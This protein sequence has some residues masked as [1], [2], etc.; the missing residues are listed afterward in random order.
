MH[1]KICTNLQLCRLLQQL[2]RPPAS[3][4][5]S[6]TRTGKPQ[7]PREPRE[8]K[9]AAVNAV[10]RAEYERQLSEYEARMLDHHAAVSTGRAASVSEGESS[11]RHPAWAAWAADIERVAAR[12]GANEAQLLYDEGLWYEPLD[13]EDVP[14]AYEP[15][16][17]A[18]AHRT[19]QFQRLEGLGMPP[20]TEEKAKLPWPHREWWEDR[21]RIVLLCEFIRYMDTVPPRD[22]WQKDAPTRED[23]GWLEQV[24]GR[25]ARLWYGKQVNGDWFGDDDNWRSPRAI[26]AG[27]R[28]LT[29]LPSCPRSMRLPMHVDLFAKRD[30]EGCMMDDS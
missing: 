5:M 4:D 20:T 17:Y 28:Y 1:K 2:P 25:A 9:N 14:E 19:L 30:I 7:K 15:P 6:T 16:E 3:L 27:Y 21:D 29:S 22:G 18:A 12:C 8:G 24:E 13:D 10:R 26:C 11:S 23:G